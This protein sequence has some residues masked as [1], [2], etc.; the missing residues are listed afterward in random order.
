MKNHFFL[1]HN[2]KKNQNKGDNV[3]NRPNICNALTSEFFHQLA[4]VQ[5]SLDDYQD[6]SNKWDNVEKSLH[7][8]DFPTSEPIGV[9]MQQRLDEKRNQLP[10]KL[11]KLQSFRKDLDA[12]RNRLSACP[13]YCEEF[14]IPILQEM[15]ASLQK[16]KKNPKFNAALQNQQFN[17]LSENDPEI[18]KLR[19]SQKLLNAFIE[20]PADTDILAQHQF[21][22]QEYAVKCNKN[23]T[24]FTI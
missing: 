21:L 14:V 24:R 7:M 16:L 23:T 13:H 20:K 3:D 1:F 22:L 12:Q 6:E 2:L 9:T 17:D 8:L 18:A 19:V 4:I 10:I 11:A 5:K 15:T